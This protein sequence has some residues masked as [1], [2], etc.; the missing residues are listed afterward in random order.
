MGAIFASAF[1]RAGQKIRA[2]RGRRRK[3]MI[4][5]FT[6]TRAAEILLVEDNENDVELTRIG[7]KKSKLLLNLHHVK[8]G[9]E[10]MEFLHKQ[11][12]FAGAPR[13]DM[14]LLDLN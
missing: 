5:N 3:Q 13:P 9:V 4:N 11:G 10:C 1:Q 6:G 7:L 14:I 8:D 12:A 2:K